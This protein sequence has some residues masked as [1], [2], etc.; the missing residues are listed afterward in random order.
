MENII[1][2][3][4]DNGISI[5]CGGYMIYFQLTTMKDVINTLSK[6]EENLILINQKLK[7]DIKKELR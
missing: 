6:I 7:I 4:A 5:V 2:V 1:K 3:I